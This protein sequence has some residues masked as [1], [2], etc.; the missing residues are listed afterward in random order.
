MP[1]RFDFGMSIISNVKIKLIEL[2]G[3]K[4]CNCNGNKIKGYYY[5]LDNWAILSEK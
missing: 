5:I 4:C 2:L 3:I 1:L